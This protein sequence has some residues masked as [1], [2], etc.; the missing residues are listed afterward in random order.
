LFQERQNK[1]LKKQIE[2][3]LMDSKTLVKTI[4]ELEQQHFKLVQ[5]NVEIDCE[6]KYEQDSL[7]PLPLPKLSTISTRNESIDTLAQ[8]I[9]QLE[10]TKRN[11]TMT[12]YGQKATLGLPSQMGCTKYYGSLVDSIN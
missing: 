3:L 1:I 9:I 8:R 4:E 11:E 6:F 12:I 5:Q 2:L 10:I 7:P